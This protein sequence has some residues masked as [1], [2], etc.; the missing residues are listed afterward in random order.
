MPSHSQLDFALDEA[1]MSQPTEDENAYFN[2]Q[3]DLEDLEEESLK[4]QQSELRKK[5]TDEIVIMKYENVDKKKN[6]MKVI[7]RV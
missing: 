2:E 6:Y 1:N 4:V 3:S 5:K 7:F